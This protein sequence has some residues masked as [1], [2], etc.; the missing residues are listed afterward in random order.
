MIL[1][2]KYNG[3]DF[4]NNFTRS[5]GLIDFENQRV[6]GFLNRDVEAKHVSFFHGLEQAVRLSYVSK[7]G[8]FIF[9]PYSSIERDGGV[10]SFFKLLKIF[11]PSAGTKV[12][13]RALLFDK[14]FFNDPTDWIYLG[15]LFSEIYEVQNTAFFTQNNIAYITGQNANNNN[16]YLLNQAFGYFQILNFK[17]DFFLTKKVEYAY[18][19]SRKKILSA[20]NQIGK[21]FTFLNLSMYNQ[22]L[23]KWLCNCETLTIDGVAYQLI[24]DFTEIDM[25]ESS[26]LCSLRADFIE[27]N[28]SFFSATS[29]NKPAKD[30]FPTNFYMQ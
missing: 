13:L 16:G 25:N 20:E 6:K 24:S 5:G 4:S 30:I 2:A 14:Q 1:P 21:R 23:L 28:Q 27:V 15:S 10:I 9:P 3:I 29:S 19:Y 11:L 8:E 22:N 26:E 17:T 7:F 12:Y 18:S